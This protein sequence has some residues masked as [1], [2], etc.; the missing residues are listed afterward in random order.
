MVKVLRIFLVFTLVFWS[1]FRIE[2]VAFADD[3]APGTEETTGGS[4]DGNQ[5]GTGGSGGEGDG[6]DGGGGGGTAEPGEPA[7]PEQPASTFK[8]LSVHLVKEDAEDKT[9]PLWNVGDFVYDT[10]SQRDAKDQTFTPEIA[11][12]QGELAFIP[13]IE[14]TDGTK[15]DA[16]ALVEWDVEPASRDVADFTE[17]AEHRKTNVLKAKGA[18]DDEVIALCKVKEDAFGQFN[19]AAGS[20]IEL[21]FKVKVMEQ[22]GA[23]VESIEI[24]GEDGEAHAAGETLKIDPDGAGS[25]SYQ[26]AARVTVRD[27]APG[28]DP[29]TH[30]ISTADAAGLEGRDKE[31]ID[32]L[33]W[34]VADE[35]E[36]SI[37]PTGLFKTDGKIEITVMCTSSLGHGGSSVSASTTVNTGVDPD[38]QGAS[39]PQDTLLVI[40]P[41]EVVKVADSESGSDGVGGTGAGS[42]DGSGTGT[43][44]T[45][46]AGAGSGASDA[47]SAETGME[48]QADEDGAANEPGAT[49]DGDQPG[50]DQPDSA[51]PDA[52]NKAYALSE[53]ESLPWA[54]G[55]FT[56]QGRAS[57]SDEVAGA[58]DNTTTITGT[59]PRLAT[60]LEDA[61][62]DLDKVVSVTFVNYLGEAK[63]IPWSSLASS[64]DGAF[65]AASSLVHTTDLTGTPGVGDL[66]KNT[67]FRLLV[68]DGASLDTALSWINTVRVNGEGTGGGNGGNSDSSLRAVIGYVPVAKGNTAV[69]SASV[70]G[71]YQGEQFGYEW[72]ESNDGG[73]TWS[74]TIDTAQTLRV[75]TS[76]STI[77]RMYRVIAT[78]NSGRVAESD[79]VTLRESTGFSVAL[80][81]DPPL[82]GEMAFF[83]TSVTGVDPADITDYIWEWTEDGGDTW[84]EIAGSRGNPTF[85]TKTDPIDDSDGEDGAADGDEG[86]GE[87]AGSDEGAE[88]GDGAEPGDQ[89]PAPSIWIHVRVLATEG[90]EAVSNPVMLTVHVSDDGGSGQ[91]PTEISDEIPENP[92]AP[93]TDNPVTTPEE[94]GSTVPAPTITEVDNIVME[95]APRGQ[96]SSP[97]VSTS[98]A[99][100]QTPDGTQT[101]PTPES[102]AS[103]IPTEL[104]VNPTITAEI[105]DQQAAVDAAVQASRPGA[106]WTALTTVDP[107]GKDVQRILSDNPFA[108]LTAPFALGLTAAG[109]VEKLLAFRR[110]TR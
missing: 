64:D 33:A 45:G 66:L 63:T 102:A 71:L 35:S 11:T 84:Q 12:V 68:G 54:T 52:V 9:K 7:Q 42:G 16:G 107:D 95:T 74:D 94:T 97:V 3:E 5:P 32:S 104:V 1:T 14:K 61:G 41:S 103:D 79:P 93:G 76:D 89:T 48:T 49:D 56:L 91:P 15:V 13:V 109:A 10:N 90:R 53:L 69:L 59:G 100:E 96:S 101:T 26:F 77:G 75:P 2:M 28:V 57:A 65:L 19:L 60:L 36:A 23:Y 20:V 88:S 24:L 6:G 27:P 73:M 83:T 85:S 80:A 81:Y 47:G 86:S 62:V 70:V 17:D 55:T 8:N 67:R 58:E 34:S 82:A 78:T 37:S 44:G 4:G 43:D 87:E 72:Q 105:L 30:V 38:V 108:P 92:D 99:T 25:V 39:H 22:A 46:D 21:R 29:A 98:P 18:N 31:L 110:Q 51:K 50:E 40:A 106:R